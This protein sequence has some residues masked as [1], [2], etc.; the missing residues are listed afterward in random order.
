M[1]GPLE[2][3]TRRMFEALD[4]SDAE[5][6]IALGA[7]DMQGVDEISRRWLRGSGEVGDYLRQLIGMVSG[8]R[9]TFS[10]VHEVVRDDTGILTCWLEQDYT[11]GGKA[12]HVSAP[13]T[14]VFRREFGDWKIVLFHSVPLPPE[15]AAT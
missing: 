12:E 7:Q 1:A 13:T 9:S 11:L 10:D 15:T 5:S 3:L 14:L 2:G 4:R 8:V 6:M